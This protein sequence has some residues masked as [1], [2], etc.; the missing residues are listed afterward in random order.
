MDQLNFH[1]QKLY[2]LIFGVVTLIA[3]ILP[4]ISINMGIFSTS[5]NG[6]RDT[7][8][9]TL[10]GVLGV[11]AACLMGDKTLPFDDQ[12]KKIA[13]GSFAAIL[14]G[15]LIFFLRAVFNG[16]IGYVGIGLWLTLV[17]G[18]VGLAFLLGKVNLPDINKK[19]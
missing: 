8:I 4:W 3:L 7:G 12:G 5:L 10:I 19:P 2:S 11:A 9:I 1:K 14:L 18:A 17:V 15:A 16:G 13:L 6:F